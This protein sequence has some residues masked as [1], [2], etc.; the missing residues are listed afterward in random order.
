MDRPAVR[1]EP[2]CDNH[3]PTRAI[4][5]HV[6]PL[7]RNLAPILTSAGFL[8]A[9]NGLLGTL[10]AVRAN[11][12][13]FSST[14]IGLMGTAYFIGFMAGCI[15]SPRLIV[16][17][18]HIRTFAA[19]CAISAICVL[20]MATFI[21]P[22]VWIPSR[23]AMGF[24]F[25]GLFMVLESWLNEIAQVGNRARI[26]S[27][28]RI[29]DLTGVTGTQFLLPLIGVETETIF[30]VTTALFC[31]ALVPMALSRI[32]NPKPPETA[33][34]NPKALWLLSPVA[35]VGCVIIGITGGSF[36]LIGPVYAQEIGLSID[37]LALFMS[38]GIFAGAI[39]Q[40]P[41]GSLSDRIDRRIVL[42]L[43]TT[44]AAASSLYLSSPFATDT[45]AIYMGIFLFGGFSLPLYSLSAAHAN[46]HA[47]PG[48]YVEMAAGLTFFFAVG[49]SVGPFVA[50]LVM[51]HFGARYLFSFIGIMHATLILF[52][53]Y[54]ISR[55]AAV[56][57][58][59][60]SRFTALLRTSPAIYRLAERVGRRT[61]HHPD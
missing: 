48:G 12:E 2:F 60:R 56:P 42:I 43:A 46:D 6:P 34:I 50:S 31:I 51:E 22:W 23:V 17:A 59:A 58:G 24:V 13:G 7:A 15:F 35:A 44:G 20:T 33:K 61:H 11:I 8:L 41:L 39:F 54:R 10:V 21:D 47:P 16:R 52:V 45:L 29:V 55:R 28:Y 18:G 49:A 25:S 38:L 37:Q 3:F 40:Y 5:L 19:L 53:L 57:V 4:A 14:S 32:N 27:I 30:T 26:L 1:S 36:R 9:G